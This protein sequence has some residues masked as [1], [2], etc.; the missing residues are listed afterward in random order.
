MDETDEFNQEE[1]DV[2]RGEDSP[3]LQS[4][5][6]DSINATIDFVINNT[7]LN[8]SSLVKSNMK[9][10]QCR[11]ST[12]VKYSDDSAAGPDACPATSSTPSAKDG[13]GDRDALR[14]S[15]RVKKP[16]K[17]VSFVESFNDSASDIEGD[18]DDCD[19]VVGEELQEGGGR[20]KGKNMDNFDWGEASREDG[21]RGVGFAGE[22]GSDGGGGD[23]ADDPL[24]CDTK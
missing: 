20:R 16:R 15:T 17:L 4:V 3:A 23:G 13:A 18:D 24:E 11:K 14:R 5:N 2:S 21:G 1:S 10:R 19:Y 22:E 6:S 8:Y 7:T 9:K 12:L